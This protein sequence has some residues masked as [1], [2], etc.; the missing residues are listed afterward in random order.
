MHIHSD[1][2]YE[3]FKDDSELYFVAWVP[4]DGPRIEK[5]AHLPQRELRALLAGRDWGFS[6]EQ[7]DTLFAAVS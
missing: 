5:T 3:V 2:K 1:G 6:K 4:V 7:I